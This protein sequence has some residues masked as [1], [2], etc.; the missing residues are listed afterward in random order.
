MGKMAAMLSRRTIIRAIAGVPLL[1]IA[2]KAVQAEAA[3]VPPLGE[4]V[5]DQACGGC[6]DDCT[7]YVVTISGWSEFNGEL[8]VSKDPCQGRC[9]ISR[10]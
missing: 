2:A 3:V 9:T 1:G 4:Y 7:H 5:N 10:T 6:C 8:H